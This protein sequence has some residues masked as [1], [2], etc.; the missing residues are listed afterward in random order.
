MYQPTCIGYAK[1]CT[2]V[3]VRFI[4][5]KGYVYC[6]TCKIPGRG[7]KLTKTERAI[8]LATGMIARY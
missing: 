2:S 5:S 8:L 6:A 1:P 3:D 7:R 4:D